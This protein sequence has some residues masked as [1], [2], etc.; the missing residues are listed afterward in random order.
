LLD[1]VGEP[2]VEVKAG[3]QRPITGK[4]QAKHLDCIRR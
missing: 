1:L 4:I 3:C 2:W